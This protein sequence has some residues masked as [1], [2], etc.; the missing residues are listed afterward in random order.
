MPENPLYQEALKDFDQNRFD[1]S[2]TKLRTL[3]EEYPQ[4]EDFIE[5]LA[6][7]L[8]HAKKYDESIA[9]I[10]K[11]ISLNPNSIMAQTNLSRC[12][13]AKEMILEAENA[14]NEARRLTWKAELKEKKQAMPK[15]DY[16]EKIERY[17]QVI[18]LDPSDVLGYFSLGTVY[19]DAGKKRESVDTF[20]KAIEVDPKHSGSYFG[21]GQ[22]LESLG[23]KKKAAVIYKKGIDVAREAGD[24][25]TEKKM[26]SKLRALES[27]TD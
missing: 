25:M 24:M 8:Y 18:E 12:Y 16:S 15:V 11:W 21:Y 17:K 20:R 2:I 1:E 5:S 26:E 9:V 7:V 27:P 10:K 22:S 4:N 6:V 13:V 23:D 14:Q 3:C 19:F